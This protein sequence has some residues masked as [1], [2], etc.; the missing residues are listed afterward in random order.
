MWKIRE[1]FNFGL[2]EPVPM[3]FDLDMCSNNQKVFVIA[4]CLSS[5]K[6]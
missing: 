3:N 1:S 6:E 5:K 2:R 4:R